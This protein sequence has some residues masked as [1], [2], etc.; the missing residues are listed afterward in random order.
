MGT[1]AACGC[2]EKDIYVLAA[3]S[4]TGKAVLVVNFSENTHAV[5]M[6]LDSD[7]TAYRIDENHFMEPV[8]ISPAAF[9]MEPNQVILFKK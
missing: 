6:N 1:E 8:S 9:T 2:D 3:V 7:F 5:S 4:D